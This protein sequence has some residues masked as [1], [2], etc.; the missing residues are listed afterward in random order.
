MSEKITNADRAAV[1]RNAWSRTY[2]D[3]I[4]AGEP[5]RRRLADAF[6]EAW[7][8]FRKARAEGRVVECQT[9]AY[10][11]EHGRSCRAQARVYLAG[12]L[13]AKAATAP[14]TVEPAPVD[15]RQV[16]IERIARNDEALSEQRAR[17]DQ[18]WATN[19]AEP[20]EH[21]FVRMDNTHAFG[22]DLRAELAGLESAAPAQP[23]VPVQLDLVAWL[24]TSPAM[25]P[26]PVQQQQAQAAAPDLARLQALR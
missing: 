14:V 4:L 6:R 15:A 18:W 19:H 26:Q 20:P 17:V 2:V 5:V 13:A 24:A 9:Q 3:A 7:A 21:M 22:L 16:L 10:E 12:I 23:V 8:V 11:E 1:L 25:V